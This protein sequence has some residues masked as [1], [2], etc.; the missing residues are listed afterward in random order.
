M[1]TFN[2]A[3]QHRAAVIAVVIVAGLG[4]CARDAD[5]S[6]MGA[7]IHG[8]IKDSVSIKDRLATA[9]PAQQAPVAAPAR[10]TS[11]APA[12]IAQAEPSKP[13][14]VAPAKPAGVARAQPSSAAPSAVPATPP[15]AVPP[16]TA[17]VTPAAS[18]A[19]VAAAPASAP[20]PRPP[21]ALE[22]AV[23]EGNRLFESGRV[24]AARE[25]LMK[26]L[27]G[28][29]PLA[30]TA[31]A[32]TFDPLHIVRLANPD[33]KADAEAALAIYADAH[34]LGSSEAGAALQRL[35]A[36]TGKP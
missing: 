1:R 13:A 17:A 18:A 6:G 22:Q 30:L 20:P 23:Y 4:G 3:R 32:R 29:D 19:T 9:Q 27:G 8:S 10:A 26:H 25:L 15:V 7:G 24:L 2:P 35:R 31:F 21:T 12:K 11:F 28:Q 36:V 16:P 5:R 14:S 33:A 34:R